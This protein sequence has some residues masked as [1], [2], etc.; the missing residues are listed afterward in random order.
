MSGLM[1]INGAEPFGY[2]RWTSPAV[3][4]IRSRREQ[5]KS[6]A[7]E[8][9][10]AIARRAKE[11]SVEDGQSPHAGQESD[12]QAKKTELQE[13]AADYDQEVL[14]SLKTDSYAD[15]RTVVFRSEKDVSFRDYQFY[16]LNLDALQE[17]VDTIRK[18][19]VAEE[20]LTIE[21][22]HVTCSLQGKPGQS[23]CLLVPWSKGWQAL[24]NGEPVHPDTVAGTMITIPLVDGTNEIELTY[25][26]PFLREGMYISAA[27]FGVLLI[28]IL[29]RLLAGRKKK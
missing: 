2:C 4:M 10:Q 18:G 17:A 12:V 27:A 29:Y 20:D 6:T 25:Q 26:V 13:V 14:A 19:Q 24:R 22:G 5:E 11:S 1:S 9:L 3:F 7:S 28:D 16:G 21:N 8:S 23:L 15:V